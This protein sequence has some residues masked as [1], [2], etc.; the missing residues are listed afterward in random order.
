[1]EI[2]VENLEIPTQPNEAMQ[3]VNLTVDELLTEPPP[4]RALLTYTS[5]TEGAKSQV[6]LPR[7]VVA[8]LSAPGGTGKSQLCLQLAVAVATG[9]YWLDLW[10]A[11]EAGDVC[12]VAGEDSVN[13]IRARL[14]A[15]K[16]TRDEAAAVAKR[17]HIMP[18]SGVDARWTDEHGAPTL[19]FA[20]LRERIAEKAP[21][22]VILDPGAR[23][24][25][26]D[27][28]ADNAQATAWIRQAEELQRLASSPTVLVAM[29]TRKG[30]GLDQNAVRGS[31][32]LVDGAR[33]VAALERVS[34]Q[35]APVDL[36]RIKRVKVNN[37]PPDDGAR[38][39]E[40]KPGGRIGYLDVGT[41]AQ[42]TEWK[43]NHKGGDGEAHEAEGFDHD[44]GWRIAQR[45]GTTHEFSSLVDAEKRRKAGRRG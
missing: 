24:F 41:W 5:K 8:I 35:S 14:Y 22:L 34:D 44:E 2:E 3:F 7:G 31:S 23:F 25:G 36:M 1:V 33:W 16:L 29:H 13:D 32:A 4:Q 28:E 19:A 37:C 26:P 17:V 39:V 10:H 9:G 45:N 18:T 12:F 6:W 38:I 27:V 21:A 43:E 15:L 40:R 30:G 42:W 20:A 11:P